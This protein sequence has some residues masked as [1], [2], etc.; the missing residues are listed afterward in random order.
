MHALKL[1]TG[2]RRDG[3]VEVLAGLPPG[4]RVV[5]RGAGLLDEG[6]RVAV[7]EAGAMQRADA[8]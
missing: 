1:S 2:Q 5:E 7:V 8:R 4:A 6:D 3:R